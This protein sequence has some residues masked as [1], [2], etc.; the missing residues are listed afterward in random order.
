MAQAEQKNRRLSTPNPFEKVFEFILL[1]SNFFGYFDMENGV[2]GMAFLDSQKSWCDVEWNGLSYP[3]LYKSKFYCFFLNCQLF[4][5]SYHQFIRSFVY[6]FM[7]LPN[8][9]L[10]V[11]MMVT[12]GVTNNLQGRSG[13]SMIRSVHEK[14]AQHTKEPTRNVTLS[15]LSKD[16]GYRVATS[17]WLLTCAESWNNTPLYIHKQTSTIYSHLFWSE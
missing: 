4:I 16:E 1:F 7:Y 5:K 9:F 17:I 3:L 11:D 2:N 8:L 6:S 10:V 14:V 13:V 12:R 15:Q